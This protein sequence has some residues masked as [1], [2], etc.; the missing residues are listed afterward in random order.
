MKIVNLK[1]AIIYFNQENI[2]EYLSLLNTLT[3][4]YNSDI[5]LKYM[6]NNFKRQVIKFP[7]NVNIFVMIDDNVVIGSGTLVIEQ[8]IIH[9]FSKV[10]HIED[11]VIDKN[12]QGKGY[13]KKIIEYLINFSKENNCYKITLG[14]DDDK[15]DFYK[16]CQPKKS[17][18]KVI[19]QI[20]YYLDI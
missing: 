10:G 14:C 5:E 15:I 13:G 8:K 2:I 17:K 12:Y 4:V 9:G 16:I 11:I 19:N 7:D 20:S 1:D 3:N 6:I 18:L